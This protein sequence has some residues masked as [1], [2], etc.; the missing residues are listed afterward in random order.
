LLRFRHT[1][2]RL[3]SGKPRD[4]RDGAIRQALYCQPDEARH[5][6]PVARVGMEL[7]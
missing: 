7:A 5:F 4:R 3:S 1:A 6:V 2:R